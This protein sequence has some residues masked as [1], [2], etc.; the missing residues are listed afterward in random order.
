MRVIARRPVWSG[1]PAGWPACIYARAETNVNATYYEAVLYTHSSE[2][3]GVVVSFVSYLY[4]LR[5]HEGAF[6]GPSLFL[7][8]IEI[9]RSTCG[10]FAGR[11]R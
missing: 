9:R 10:T 11:G 8:R 3:M 4:V 1:R 5:V 7:T 6:S 2:F